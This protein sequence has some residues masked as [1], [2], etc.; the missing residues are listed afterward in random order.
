MNSA[1][2]PKL[3]L[4]ELRSFPYFSILRPLW[5]NIGKLLTLNSI[6]SA[7]ECR[8][9]LDNCM[10]CISEIS[11]LAFLHWI[12]IMIIMLQGLLSGH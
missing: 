1:G 10:K 3:V 7:D 8:K 11:I 12:L 5:T 6:M 9:K 4:I 2:L